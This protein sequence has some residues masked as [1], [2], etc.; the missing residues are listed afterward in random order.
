MSI[1]PSIKLLVILFS[2]AV[3]SVMVWQLSNNLS[4]T[5]AIDSTDEDAAST[6]KDSAEKTPPV[7]I[8]TKNP[9][10]SIDISENPE[11]QKLLKKD[12][13]KK[14]Q[15]EPRPILPSS[16]SGIFIPSQK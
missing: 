13:E 1:H 15:E 3:G 10:G 2:L 9:A 6:K 11:V 16:K 14:E 8:S 4:N 7:I 12:K 5:D